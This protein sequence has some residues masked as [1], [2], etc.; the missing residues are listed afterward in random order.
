LDHYGFIFNDPKDAY[1]FY[2][3]INIVFELNHQSVDRDVPFDISDQQ[4]YFS[5]YE[6]ER[7]TNF[8]NL[9]PIVVD[10]KLEQEGIGPLLESS[11]TSRNG[12]WYIIMTV[13]DEGGN[14]ALHP[15]HAMQKPVKAYLNTL[16]KKL[17]ETRELL[18]DPVKTKI[19]I[20]QSGSFSL[21]KKCFK[22]QFI[23]TN[24]T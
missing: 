8:V 1:E 19:P 15:K 5:F 23:I 9:V 3:Y 12:Q 4:F 18:R 2:D 11:Y 13:F 7:S 14:D 20:K 16:R 24:N 10:A 6:A 17:F 21:I 22:L